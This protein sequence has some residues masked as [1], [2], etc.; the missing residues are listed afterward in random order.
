MGGFLM[1]AHRGH[2]NLFPICCGEERLEVQKR[3]PVESRMGNP[4]D[5]AQANQSFFLDLIP[6]EKIPVIIK[7]PQEPVEFPESPRGAVEPTGNALSR[8]L[9]RLEDGEAQ[10][11]EGLLGMPATEG[12]LN[13]N[14]K[15]PI[16]GVVPVLGLL[17]EACNVPFHEFTSLVG[18]KLFR[19]QTR[20]S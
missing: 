1:C 8:V 11:E 20:P 17:V 16:Q 12:A 3:S 7:V 9:L 4:Q 6:P 5:S 10:G 2:R 19:W 14:Q 18:A 13:A 15:K